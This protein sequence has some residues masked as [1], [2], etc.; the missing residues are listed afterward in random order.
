MMFANSSIAAA[1]SDFGVCPLLGQSGGT[2][3]LPPP[4]STTAEVVDSLFY[5]IFAVSAFFFILIVALMILFVILYRRRPG[6]E[7]QG[8]THHNTALELIWTIIPLAIVMVI[9]YWGFTA[10]MDMRTSPRES[11]EI[12]VVGQKWSWLF[13]Y[14]NGY[15]DSELHVPV[16]KPVRLIMT[17]EDVIHSLFIPAFRV[18]MDLVPGRYTQTWFHA[19]EPGSYDLYCAEYCG[20]GHSDM[21]SK[22]VVHEP[23]T[24]ETWLEN[25]GNLL[26][27]MTPVEAGETLYRRRGCGQCHSTDGTARAGGGPTF[28]GIYGQ[29]HQM[30]DGSRVEVEDN[31]I[32]E[33]ILEPQAKIRAGYEPIMPTYKGQLSDEEIT[34]IIE[35][36]KSL[37]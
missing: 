14:P 22:V 17:S 31:Y 27:T 16:A 32:R 33:S 19:V 30:T 9:F 24:F 12:R 20:T 6:V 28:Q 23:G 25:A 8:T 2:F 4:R 35:F 7:P 37:E 18:K 34:A 5:F 11:Y 13:K 10:Y 26:A 15:V 21:L 1:L 3:W 29:T 36:I